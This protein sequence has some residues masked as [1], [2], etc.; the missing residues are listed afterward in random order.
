[1]VDKRTARVKRNI[2]LIRI[3]LGMIDE[4]LQEMKEVEVSALCFV[5]YDN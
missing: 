2:A 4:A 3:K 1:M 5:K